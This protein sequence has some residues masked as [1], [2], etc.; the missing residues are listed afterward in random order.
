MEDGLK[1]S[2]V[3]QHVKPVVGLRLRALL[4]ELRAYLFGQSK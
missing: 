2:I 3:E 4:Y 1:P